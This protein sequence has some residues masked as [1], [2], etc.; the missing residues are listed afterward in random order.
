M[1]PHLSI[2]TTVRL[3][4]PQF[5]DTENAPYYS[6]TIR[7]MNGTIRTII[8]TNNDTIIRQEFR[9]KRNKAH[10]LY[11]FVRLYLSSEIRLLNYDNKQ[12]YGSVLSDP[13]L[14]QM[15]YV[16]DYTTLTLDF[17]GRLYV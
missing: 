6:N 11:E 15:T 2:E 12:Y 4:N 5:S 10:E 17:R 14:L 1:A 9:L 3:P 16:E 13:F 7:T 8:K